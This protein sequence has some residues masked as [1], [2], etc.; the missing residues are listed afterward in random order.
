MKRKPKV[1]PWR[2]WCIV[3]PDGQF[4][5]DTAAEVQVSAEIGFLRSYLQALRLGVQP[6][7]EGK[8]ESL[9]AIAKRKGYRCIRIELRALPDAKPPKRGKG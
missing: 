6:F 3:R 7:N 5:I 1:K 2:G 9:E 8:D 4:L